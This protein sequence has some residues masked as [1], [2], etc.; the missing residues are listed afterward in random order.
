M[1]K[2][3]RKRVIE[4]PSKIQKTSHE[5]MQKVPLSIGKTVDGE[6][7]LVIG[8]QVKQ[9]DEI[10]SL[11]YE[12]SK[13]FFFLTELPS[14]NANCECIKLDDSSGSLV[15]NLYYTN[16]HPF[17]V[18]LPD[19]Q[20][21]FICTAV[22]ENTAENLLKERLLQF[23]GSTMDL[24]SDSHMKIELCQINLHDFDKKTHSYQLTSKKY[25][26]E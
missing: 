21:G 7:E 10:I 11:T 17:L 19:N 5:S 22:D 24:I 12:L 23:C 14:N 2:R 6:I 3:T 13:G 15:P 8:D 20:Q 1:P 16:E 18:Y 9:Y 4:E 26:I 25:M